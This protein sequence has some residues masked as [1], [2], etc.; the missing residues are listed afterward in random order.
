MSQKHEVF[1]YGQGNEQRRRSLAMICKAG[2]GPSWRLCCAILTLIAHHSSS[3]RQPEPRKGV[4]FTTQKASQ[5]FH[6]LLFPD[7]NVRSTSKQAFDVWELKSISHVHVQSYTTFNRWVYH[8]IQQVIGIE[9][10]AQNIK[11]RISFTNQQ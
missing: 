11:I 7:N 5:L 4:S 1:V 3:F 6:R 2:M 10:E 8:F 9:F